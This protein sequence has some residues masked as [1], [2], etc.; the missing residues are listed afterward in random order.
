MVKEG[1]SEAVGVSVAAS[2]AHGTE[3]MLTREEVVPFN[4]LH[5][6][7]ILIIAALLSSRDAFAFRSSSTRLHALIKRR[8]IAEIVVQEVIPLP[9]PFNAASAVFCRD[10]DVS[11]MCNYT[12]F[13]GLDESDASADDDDDA[14]ADD[15]DDAPADDDEDAPA[16][17]DDDA[18]LEE[19]TEDETAQERE[20][21]EQAHPLARLW[22]FFDAWALNDEWSIIA[23]RA[24]FSVGVRTAHAYRRAVWSHDALFR[25]YKRIATDKTRSDDVHA[26]V[27]LAALVRDV[28]VTDAV[29]AMISAMVVWQMP[30]SVEKLFHF[31]K[32]ALERFDA[33]SVLAKSDMSFWNNLIDS[34]PHFMSTRY[35]FAPLEDRLPRIQAVAKLYPPPLLSNE[36]FSDKL[37]KCKEKKVVDTLAPFVGSL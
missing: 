26:I 31:Y 30:I 8:S 3:I 37:H 2:A 5:D 27:I 13:Y 19:P 28:G 9:I 34:Y 16:D 29:N 23:A 15:D 22:H 21:D 36:T 24:V 35:C 7:V 10:G 4:R 17:D 33:A 14:F 32:Y 11:C 12:E 18:P 20:W 6:D 25:T 1:P